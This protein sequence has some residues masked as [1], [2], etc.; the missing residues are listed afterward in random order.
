[1]LC[2]NNKQFW[3][4]RLNIEMM[5]LRIYLHITEGAYQTCSTAHIKVLCIDVGNNKYFSPN[6]LNISSYLYS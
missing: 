1:M 2:M 6:I 3:S 5:I 4:S